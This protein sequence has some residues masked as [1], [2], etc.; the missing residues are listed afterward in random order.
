MNHYFADNLRK[1]R[2][3][4]IRRTLI[5]LQSWATDDAQREPLLCLKDTVAA[6]VSNEEQTT[7]D[8]HDTL[9]AYYK[10]ARKRFVDAVCL[11]AVDYF[12]VSNKDGP[13]WL[14]SPHFVGGLSNSDLSKIAGEG[15][16][17]AVRR[18]RLEEEIATLK[19]GEIILVG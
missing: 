10:V 14:L 16:E 8:L 19:A 11:Q 3:D 13:L 9:E 5:S 7:Q 6:F 15:D 1:A 2:E 17:V 18:E 4:R 12:L